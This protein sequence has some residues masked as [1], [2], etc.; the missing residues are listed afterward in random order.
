[1]VQKLEQ[2]T[3]KDMRHFQNLYD[4]KAR[5][6][7]PLNDEFFIIIPEQVSS[8]KKKRYIIEDVEFEDLPKNKPQDEGNIAY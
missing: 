2:Q 6:S 4:E 5:H 3:L 1:M 8:E 7:Y